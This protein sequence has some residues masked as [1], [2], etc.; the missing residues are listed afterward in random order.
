MISLCVVD[1]K[2][3]IIV[4][5]TSKLDDYVNRV[6]LGLNEFHWCCVFCFFEF[7]YMFDVSE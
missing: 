1:S 2:V 7:L 4:K 3:K 5:V 6:K